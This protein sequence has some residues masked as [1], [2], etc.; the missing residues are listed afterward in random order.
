MTLFYLVRH[1]ETE[2]NR[3]GNR[4]CG[5]SDIS[6]SD[7]GKRQAELV[8]DYL[9]HTTFDLLF[10]SPLQR[11]L[12][13]CA[14]IAM[15]R[16]QSIEQDERLTEIDF[17]CWEGVQGKEIGSRFPSLWNPWLS[18]PTHV[19]AGGTGETAAEVFDRMYRFFREQAQLH[20]DKLVLAVG[21]NTAIRLFIAGILEMPFQHYRR[22]KKSNAGVTVLEMTESQVELH[23]FNMT[24]HSLHTTL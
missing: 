19:R 5:R 17:G 15:N 9:Q 8:S 7:T 6:L 11:A 23:H 24:F 18:D 12:Q 3:E 22:L 4:Y 14:P 1:G 20:P 2:W 21:H 10:S 13:T 16:S